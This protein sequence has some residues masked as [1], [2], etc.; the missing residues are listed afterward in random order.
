M[1]DYQPNQ[2]VTWP[3][4]EL[5]PPAEINLGPPPAS[6]YQLWTSESWTYASA[7]P[8]AEKIP[9]SYSVFWYEPSAPGLV[10]WQDP[11]G[12]TTQVWTMVIDYEPN[13]QFAIQP[14]N[15]P[16]SN[17]SPSGGGSSF[18]EIANPEPSSIALLG[19]GL[20]CGGAWAIRKSRRTRKNAA[21]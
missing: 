15:L 21:V 3:W 20:L 19:A 2:P 4:P 9:T 12:L 5:N 16:E 14:F 7:D 18:D 11:D 13:N 1:I 8:G 10:P 17:F 6:S